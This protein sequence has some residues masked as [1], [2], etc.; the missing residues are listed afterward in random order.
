MRDTTS[1]PSTLPW[2]A[3][4]PPPPPSAP[5]P[6]SASRSPT[7]TASPSGTAAPK[8][9]CPANLARPPNGE[10]QEPPASGPRR[11]R[12]GTGPHHHHHRGASIF[13][14][15]SE[16]RRYRPGGSWAVR[17]PGNRLGARSP[18]RWPARRPRL[19][20]PLDT[21][22]AIGGPEYSV[23]LAPVPD[24]RLRSPQRVARLQAQRHPPPPG[25]DPR[26]QLHVPAVLQAREGQRLRACGPL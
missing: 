15:Q 25:P 21:R 22:P 24:V 6:P 10:P 16:R 18:R 19:V 1:A 23:N 14:L 5:T 13:L 4:W 7:P 3:P 20:R 11:R 8:P 2:P 12:P 17:A 9:A 26:S